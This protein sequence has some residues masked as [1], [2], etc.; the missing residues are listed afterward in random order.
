MPDRTSAHYL[1]VSFVAGAELA[2]AWSDA[3]LAAGAAA[4]DAA[5]AHAGTAKETA[6]YGEPATAPWPVVRLTALFDPAVSW[7]AMLA[8]AAASVGKPLPVYALAPVA[9]SDWIRASQ[10]QFQPVR[11]SERLLIVPSWCPAP[12]PGATIVTLDPGL[13][14]GTGTHPSTL[15]CLRWLAACLRAGASVLDYGCGS[16]ILAIAAAKL[17]AATAV[18]VDIDPQAVATSRANAEINR[19]NAT[20]ASPDELG[21]AAFD[22]ALANI[23]AG[24]L[25]LLA[26]LLSSR[27]RPGGSL[28]LSGILEDQAAGVRAAY[29]RWFNIAAWG[30]IEGW[31]ALAGVRHTRADEP[32]ERADG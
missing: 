1:A 24:P 15:L 27:V 4:V 32:I 18:G 29:G 17:G 31:V 30:S 22:V 21:F 6:A 19:V 9:N 8:S 13:A 10:A 28:V 3:L 25:E 20:F 26:P 11:V 5:D 16:G 2:E 12:D 23:L 14:F 7:E